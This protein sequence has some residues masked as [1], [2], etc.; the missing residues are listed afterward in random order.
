MASGTRRDTKKEEFWRRRLGAQ[1]RSGL[2]VRAWCRQHDTQESAFY[3]WRTQLA[4]RDAE[5]PPF[6][7]VRVVADTAIEAG[8][9]EIVLPSDYRVRVIGPVERQM[10][11]E[12]LA[13]LTSQPPA[14]ETPG[15]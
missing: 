5:A 13:V 10:L 3:W 15:C 6:A 12:V 7:P 4:R 9:I 2:S 1:A 8:R 14:A 11:V